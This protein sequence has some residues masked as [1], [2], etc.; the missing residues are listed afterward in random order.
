MKMIRIFAFAAFA[1]VISGCM[2]PLPIR[3]VPLEHTTDT[4]KEALLGP[5][6]A[7]TLQQLRS[8]LRSYEVAYTE[9]ADARFERFMKGSDTT[10]GGG[11]IG[12]IGGLT[13]SP[14]TSIM[15]ALL[16]AGGSYA[17]QRYQLQVQAK[18]FNRAAKAMQCLG[19]VMAFPPG[20]PEISGD[21]LL[22]ASAVSLADDHIDQVKSRLRDAQFAVTPLDVDVEK[23]RAGIRGQIESMEERP[24]A[25][26]A[27]VARSA[28]KRLRLK[29]QSLAE[30]E[31]PAT[32]A[33]KRAKATKTEKAQSAAAAA[34]ILVEE[35][36]EDLR[37]NVLKELGGRLAQCSGA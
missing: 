37:E 10:A 21:A 22:I 20:P 8:N 28:E 23:V 34:A 33:G 26:S 4:K 2:R 15:G 14:Q 35:A 19:R 13:K 17:E 1:V 3:Q 25:I 9:Q 29:A 5:T 36:E 6:P 32:D 27:F 18:N 24:A 7:T 16:G 31:A 30:A 12:T 11:I